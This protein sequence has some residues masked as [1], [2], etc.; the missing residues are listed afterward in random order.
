MS[1]QDTAIA[2]KS[3]TGGYTAIGALGTFVVSLLGLI[4]LWVKFGPKWREIAVSAEQGFRDDLISRLEKVEKTL[5][6]ERAQHEAERSLDRHKFN[7]LSQ[8]FDAVMLMLEAT[9]EK[10]PEIV[11]RIK[12]MRATQLQAEAL[13][14][15]A[16][17]AAR[18]E[19]AQ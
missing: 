18:M 7:N 10:A 11:V 8:C 1:L 5:E 4:G 16:I 15:A 17:H 3:A 9:P 6:I 14:K 13:E 19:H 12:E 2:V